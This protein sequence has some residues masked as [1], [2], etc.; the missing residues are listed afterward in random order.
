[1][2]STEPKRWECK[3]CGFISSRCK[4]K[5]FPGMAFAVCFKCRGPVKEREEWVS[6]LRAAQDRFYGVVKEN[7]GTLRGRK[8]E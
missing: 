5:K 6:W 8:I 1:M 3:D 7:G 4:K 2:T